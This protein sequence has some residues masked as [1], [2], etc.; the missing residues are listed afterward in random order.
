MECL[1]VVSVMGVVIV[2]T[3]CAPFEMHVVGSDILVTFL[4]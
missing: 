2:T 1:F 4:E 3:V